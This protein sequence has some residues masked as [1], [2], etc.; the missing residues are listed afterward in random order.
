MHLIVPDSRKSN[1]VLKYMIIGSWEITL[2]PKSYM[3][4]QNE[5]KC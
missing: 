3:G 4:D 2:G 5:G 1:A